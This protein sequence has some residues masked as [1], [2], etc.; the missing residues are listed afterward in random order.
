MRQEDRLEGRVQNIDEQI[1]KL[2]SDKTLMKVVI[3]TRLASSSNRL[4][5]VESFS[6]VTEQPRRSL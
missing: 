2:E 4:A 3:E 1:T 5:F 6:D